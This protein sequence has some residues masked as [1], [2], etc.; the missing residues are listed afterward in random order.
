MVRKNIIHRIQPRYHII[1][2]ERGREYTA[3]AGSMIRVGGLEDHSKRSVEEYLRAVGSES[4][5]KEMKRS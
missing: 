5:L 4:T 2:L 1:K 3:K